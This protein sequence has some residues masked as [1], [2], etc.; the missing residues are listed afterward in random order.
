[1]AEGLV[2]GV[3]PDGS[4]ERLLSE[5][6]PAINAE[7]LPVGERSFEKGYVFIRTWGMEY[8]VLHRVSADGGEAVPILPELT[9]V[10]YF[11]WK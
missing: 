8:S 2:A 6:H 5:A 10:T 9:N 1:M 11:D 4:Q 3:R 7:W